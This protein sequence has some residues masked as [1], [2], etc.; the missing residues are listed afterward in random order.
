MLPI[1][2]KMHQSCVYIR[3]VDDIRILGKNEYEVRKALVDLDVLCRERGL[4]PSSEKTTIIKI[5][6]EEKLVQNIPPILLYQE[7]YGPKQI[8][9]EGAETGLNDALS[10]SN[11]TIEI[12]DKSKFRYILFRAGPSD[13]ILTIVVGLWI[14]NPH[15]IDAFASFLENYDRVDEIVNLCTQDITQSPYDFVSA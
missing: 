4:I 3:Y 8:A 14:H 15:Q 9:E 10:L 2:E 12:I 7:T 13:K 6:D 1:D 11:N 5:E